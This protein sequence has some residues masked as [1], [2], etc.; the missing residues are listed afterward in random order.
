M[1]LE[2]RFSKINIG[3]SQHFIFGAVCKL[4]QIVSLD[5]LFFYPAFPID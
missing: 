1:E 2:E 4:E 5:D 3:W